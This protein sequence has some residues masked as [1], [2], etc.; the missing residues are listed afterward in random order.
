VGGCV[1]DLLLGTTQHVGDDGGAR[2]FNENHM[3]EADAVEAI[4]E[5]EDALDLIRLDHGC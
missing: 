1:H 4:F 2:N 3:V 5:C